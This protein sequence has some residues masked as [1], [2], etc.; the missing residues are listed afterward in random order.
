M[1][2]D[3]TL[4]DLLSRIVDPRYIEAW[5]QKPNPA[6]ENRKPIDVWDSPDR[7]RIYEM[8]WR[9]EDSVQHEQV[10]PWIAFLI[11]VGVGVIS[12]LLILYWILFLW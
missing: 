11:G 7:Q 9:M 10:Q 8:V 6:F 1:I 12:T 3:Q 4:T 5:L 2:T